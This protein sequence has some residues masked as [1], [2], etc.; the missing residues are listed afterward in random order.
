M[1][2]R[3]GAYLFKS[4]VNLTPGDLSQPL[5]VIDD[6]TVTLNDMES[7][8]LAGVFA[9]YESPTE[10]WVDIYPAT[11]AWFMNQQATA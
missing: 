9:R 10:A 6:Q 3:N 7:K 1:V 2:R 5:Y 11:S 8:V 4:A